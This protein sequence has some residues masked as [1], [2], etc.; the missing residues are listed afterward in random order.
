[1]YVHGKDLF[2]DDGMKASARFLVRGGW[3]WGEDQA[4]VDPVSGGSPRGGECL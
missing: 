4:K 2:V 3:G 1:M